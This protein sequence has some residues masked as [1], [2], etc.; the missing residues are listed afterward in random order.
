MNMLE[1]KPLLLWIA[2]LLLKDKEEIYMDLDVENMNIYLLIMKFF[3]FDKNSFFNIKYNK[4][5]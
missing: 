2:Y 5:H 1:E 3:D 4:I